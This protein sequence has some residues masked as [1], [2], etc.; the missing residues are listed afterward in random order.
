MEFFEFFDKAGNLNEEMLTTRAE[1]WAKVFNNRDMKP[2]QMR[3]FYHEVK[4]LEAIKNAR[5]WE[6][7]RPLVKMLKSKV[8]YASGSKES[9][10]KVPGEFKEFID[11][12]VT[13]TNTLEDFEAF[14]KIFEAVM[15]YFT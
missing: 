9:G 7:T 15:G 12:C 6:K 8:A 2:T 3:K 14:S 1:K 13:K 10:S 5:G 4:S 11:A